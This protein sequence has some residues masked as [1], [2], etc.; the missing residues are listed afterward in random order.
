MNILDYPY[1]RTFVVKWF[2]VDFWSE[3]AKEVKSSFGTNG[4]K[5]ASHTR[6]GG[7]GGSRDGSDAGQNQ[8]QVNNGRKSVTS[9]I[10]SHNHLH[11]IQNP[12]KIDFYWIL[13]FSIFLMKFF[14][15]KL[16]FSRILTLKTFLMGDL[17][18][19]KGWWMSSN[20]N[21]WTISKAKVSGSQW[22]RLEIRPLRL[23]EIGWIWKLCKMKLFLGIPIN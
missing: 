9:P 4:L 13:D 19:H 16:A 5:K 8:T 6:N 1:I 22:H 12:G 17:I 2:Q 23:L 18:P 20:V 15:K 11:I 14:Q 21:P 3:M 7:R 10:L